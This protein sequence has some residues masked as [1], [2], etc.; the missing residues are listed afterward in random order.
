MS[1]WILFIA[2]DPSGDL[3]GSRLISALKKKDPGLKA[4][5]VGGEHM[6]EVADLFL[7]DLASLGISGFWEPIRKGLL[8]YKLLKQIR[9]FLEEEK[10][11]AFIAIDFYGFNHQVLGLAKHRGIPSFYYISP[12]VW[13]SRP[14][15]IQR[16]ARLIRHMLVIFPFEV[17]IY[18][19]AGIP[20][21]F[22]GHPLL[23]LLPNP[24]SM[25]SPPHDE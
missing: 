23:D 22:V 13:A 15:R 10:P 2:G 19:G 12:Q 6:R 24:G 14:E 5:A 8:W 4:A 20:C 11:K 7:F 18:E 25:P 1:D 16:L 3:H 9:R 17:E 21:S